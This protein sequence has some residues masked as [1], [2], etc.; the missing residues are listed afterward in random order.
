MCASLPSV[1]EPETVWLDTY[2]VRLEE[3]IEVDCNPAVI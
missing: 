3:T 1:L 2:P